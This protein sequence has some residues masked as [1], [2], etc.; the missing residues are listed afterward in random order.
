MFQDL[1]LPKHF[2]DVL[3]T[4]FEVIYY[5]EV[6][7]YEETYAMRFYTFKY[8]LEVSFSELHKINK[9]K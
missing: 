2:V 8:K 4:V 5:K 1:K 9:I 3:K 6:Y 7:W